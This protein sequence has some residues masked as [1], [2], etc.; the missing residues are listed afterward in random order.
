[1]KD[2]PMA[3]NAFWSITVYDKDGYPQGEHFSLN[4][5]FATENDEGETIVRFGGS[6][7]QENYLEIYEG[8]NATF[9]IY[10]PQAEYFDGSWEVPSPQ[11]VGN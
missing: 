2:V 10:S 1:M 4:S 6:P 3:N 5:T 11:L 7:D 9:R 8:W